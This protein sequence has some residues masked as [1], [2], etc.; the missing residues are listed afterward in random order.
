MSLHRY[1]I[2]DWIN[3]WE[4]T[5][6]YPVQKILSSLVEIPTLEKW[7]IPPYSFPSKVYSI[8]M[9]NIVTL[10][11]RTWKTLHQPQDQGQHQ[12]WLRHANT[13]HLGI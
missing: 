10:Q 5:D 1:K 9:G 12:Q 2:H 6:T 13:M 4:T 8:N 7:S 11:W 3:N